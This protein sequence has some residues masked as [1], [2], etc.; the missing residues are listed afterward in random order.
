MGQVCTCVVNVAMFLR[1]LNKQ[2]ISPD[3]QLQLNALLKHFK[4]ELTFKLIDTRNA[5]G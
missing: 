4:M 3:N 2:A 5:S 1:A